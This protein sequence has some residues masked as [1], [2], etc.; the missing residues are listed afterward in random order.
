M[1]RGFNITYQ[2]KIKQNK[3]RVGPTTQHN[4]CTQ[5]NNTPNEIQVDECHGDKQTLCRNRSLIIK[6]TEGS[7]ETYRGYTK[8]IEKKQEISDIASVNSLC[9]FFSTAQQPKKS[10][11][12]L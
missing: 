3:T 6:D 11:N 9:Q 4:T 5:P 7:S 2:N 8:E 10:Q 12:I 1:N